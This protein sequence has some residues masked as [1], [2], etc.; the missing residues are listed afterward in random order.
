MAEIKK[1]CVGFFRETASFAHNSSHR[2]P[3]CSLHWS[4][5]VLSFDTLAYRFFSVE[6]L[7]SLD[8]R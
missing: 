8:R 5:F 7:I 1:G 3:L 4:W 2:Q 6:Y